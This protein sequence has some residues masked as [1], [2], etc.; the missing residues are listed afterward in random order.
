MSTIGAPARKAIPR[1]CEA[2]GM[3]GA[4]ADE[5]NA[6]HLEKKAVF[7]RFVIAGDIVPLAAA[8]VLESV[9]GRKKLALVSSGNREGVT[10][11]LSAMQWINAFDVVIS[12]DDVSRGKPDPEPYLA[13]AAALNVAPRECLV[14]E[15]T[16]AGL[17]SGRAAGMT[18]LD[19]AEL[20]GFE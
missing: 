15:D 6:I 13:A 11:L 14:L 18:V 19:V 7:E 3:K 9:R 4:T 8:T 20:A 10:A 12:G 5:V 1:F 16:E 17:A 2:T